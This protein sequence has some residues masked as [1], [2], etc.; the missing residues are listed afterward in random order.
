MI[1]IPTLQLV[2]DEQALRR[3]L[4]G[5]LVLTGVL[6][7]GVLFP[8]RLSPLLYI[9]EVAPGTGAEIYSDFTRIYYAGDMVL[10]A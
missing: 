1:F 10:Y 6:L 9:E 4:I 3:L 7:F 5:L 2:R 8:N